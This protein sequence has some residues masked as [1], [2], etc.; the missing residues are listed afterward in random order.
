MTFLQNDT[1]NRV[2]SYFDLKLF[3][4][5]QQLARH[6]VHQAQQNVEL[7]MTEADGKNLLDQ[8]L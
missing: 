2:G 1:Q 8:L 5:A 3:L 6:I 7:G 4:E